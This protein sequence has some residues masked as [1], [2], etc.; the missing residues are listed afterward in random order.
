MPRAA[1]SVATRN[2][3]LFRRSFSST[4]SR[5]AWVRSALISP[6]SYPKRRRTVATKC[7]SD[8]VLQKMMAE[9][10]FSIS[11]ILTRMRLFCMAGTL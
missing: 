5:A 7:T 2:L 3:S 8:L 9:A 6:T 4:S 1:T 10:G 11:M